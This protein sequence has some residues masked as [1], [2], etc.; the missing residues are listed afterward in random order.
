MAFQ[1]A[2][3]SRISARQTSSFSESRPRSPAHTCGGRI[4]RRRDLE[5]ANGEDELGRAV[6]AGILKP[7]RR[8]VSSPLLVDHWKSLVMFVYIFEAQHTL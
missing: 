1:R 4:S 5:R 6:V 7:P 2:T 8:S 3:R